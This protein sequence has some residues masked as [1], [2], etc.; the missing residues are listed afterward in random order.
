MLTEH[1]LYNDTFQLVWEKCQPNF[2]TPPDEEP[3]TN[4]NFLKW[5]QL[6]NGRWYQGEVNIHGQRDGRGITID[7]N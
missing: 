5:R 6:P 1:G 2:G 7:P 3:P 4:R